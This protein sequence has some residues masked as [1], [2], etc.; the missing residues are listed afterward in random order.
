MSK[1]RRRIVAMAAT[2]VLTAGFLF[3]P[4]AKAIFGFG[5]MVFDPTA[6]GKLIQQIQQYQQMLQNEIQLYQTTKTQYEM[7]RFNL[8]QYTNKQF[9]KTWGVALL[10]SSVSNRYGET[11]AWNQA[12]NYGQGLPAAWSLA[13]LPVQN[14]EFLARQTLGTSPHLSSLAAVEIQDSAGQVSMA[15]LAAVREQQTANAGAINQLEQTALGGDPADNTEIKQLNLLNA[16]Q[17]QNMRMQQ[18]T[19]ALQ[20]EILEQLL[21]ANLDQ[22]NLQANALN[23][24]T[25]ATTYELS[26]PTAPANLAAALTTYN[27]Q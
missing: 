10:E 22:R 8:E 26:E 18:G 3:T 1:R 14:G 2:V 7:L 23:V 6:V 12:V 24:A 16:A 15:T 27:P 5:D 20:A 17:L 4:P 21:A 9:W 25:R 13:T 11:A 19:Q